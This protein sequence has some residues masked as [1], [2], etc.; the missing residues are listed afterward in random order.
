MNVQLKE[1]NGTVPMTI[2]KTVNDGLWHRLNLKFTADSV[3]LAID[4]D[5]FTEFRHD[6]K[7]V[8]EFSFLKFGG[9]KFIGCFRN[10]SVNEIQEKFSD[11]DD[12]SPKISKLGGC[13]IPSG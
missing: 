10:L 2:S 5:S 8:S 3:V 12:F 11:Y 6:F 4:S 7:R 1:L 9:E 13:E